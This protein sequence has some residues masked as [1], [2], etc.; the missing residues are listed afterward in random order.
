MDQEVGDLLELAG[1]RDVEDVVA[2][3]VQVIAA[4]A[5]GADR[6]VAG[7]DAGEGD[8]LLRLEAGRG[9][10]VVRSCLALPVAA[11]ELVELALVVVI[12]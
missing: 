1:L 2:A 12:A 4:A 8:G 11:E 9:R 3:V 10:A 6:R 7:D 5:D